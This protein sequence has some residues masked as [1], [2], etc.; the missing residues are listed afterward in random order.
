M[1]GGSVAAPEARATAAA[2]PGGGGG[3]FGEGLPV[4]GARREDGR[5]REEAMGNPFEASPAAEGARG[6]VRDGGAVVWTFGGGGELAGCSGAREKRRGRRRCE[7]E[8][9]G[10][11]FIG[12]EGEGERG[13]VARRPAVM[14]PVTRVLRRGLM[15]E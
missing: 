3:D 1:A 6:G 13:V 4:A 2:W 10:A 14:A 9:P 5:E 7:E 8:V 15:G 11:A 12:G